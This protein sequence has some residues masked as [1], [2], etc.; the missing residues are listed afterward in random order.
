MAVE[1]TR[2]ARSALDTTTWRSATAATWGRW[3]TTSTWWR[4]ARLASASATAVAAD[5]PMPA[6]TSSKTSVA[7]PAVRTQAQGEHH[8]GQLASG[9]DPAEG[10]HRPAAVRVE[11]ERHLVARVVR[12][13]GH[14]ECGVG[15]GER[16]E[17]GADGGGEVRR[18]GTACRA[19]RG[20]RRVAPLRRRG[21][22]H[23]QLGRPLVV[24]L[25]LV[26]AASQLGRAN[27]EDRRPA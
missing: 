6:S 16:G 17:V 23:L 1:A 12:A 18:H 9:R 3:V 10:Q 19:H 14:V 11:P 5:P 8:P 15:Q 20:G 26:D 24:V 13:D 2:P 22:G 27:D 21:E 7:G 25:E 4:R